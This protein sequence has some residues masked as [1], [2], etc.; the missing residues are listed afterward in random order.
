M[1]YARCPFWN[2]TDRRTLIVPCIRFSFCPW[3]LIEDAES[4][5]SQFISLEWYGS[6]A[7]FCSRHRMPLSTCCECFTPR[8]LHHPRDY[9]T[10]QRL[11]CSDCGQALASCLPTFDQADS[12]AVSALT[13]FEDLLRKAVAGKSVLVRGQYSVLPG[14]LLRFVEDIT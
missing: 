1:D 10:H 6:L 9:F 13:H 12:G 14:S 8:S 11:Y 2:D 7:K 3:C 5:R 4:R